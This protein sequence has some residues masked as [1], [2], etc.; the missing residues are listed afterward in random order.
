MAKML[1]VKT[2]NG[3]RVTAK[4]AGIESTA[5]IRSVVSTSARTTKSGVAAVRSVP[6]SRSRVKNFCPS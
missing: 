3:L 5:K 2:R 1:E 6:S 4:M